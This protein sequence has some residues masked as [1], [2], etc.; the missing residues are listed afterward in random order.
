[1]SGT[2]LTDSAIGTCNDF[3]SRNVVARCE[4][5]IVLARALERES[6]ELRRF[7]AAALTLTTEASIQHVMSKEKP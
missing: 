1:M 3:N 4:R 7:K 2:P 5:L 6:A